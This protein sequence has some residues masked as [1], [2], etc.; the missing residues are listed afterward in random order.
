MFNEP[1]LCS[2]ICLLLQDEMV[3]SRSSSWK[4]TP[5]DG[6]TLAKYL[7]GRVQEAE[8]GGRPFPVGVRVDK[9][10]KRQ[11]SFS[12]A[13]FGIYVSV[14]VEHCTKLTW[15]IVFPLQI[16]TMNVFDLVDCGIFSAKDILESYF[17]AISKIWT[18]LETAKKVILQLCTS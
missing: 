17:F 11:L 3:A 13:G 10:V 4:P 18:A 12:E 6:S 9:P 7:L 2:V 1:L 14:F 15:K 8:S 16:A 5:C